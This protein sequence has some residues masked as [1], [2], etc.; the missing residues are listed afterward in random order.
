MTMFLSSLCNLKVAKKF[1]FLQIKRMQEM[2][3]KMQAQLQTTSPRAN[4]RVG[5]V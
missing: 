4:G 2:L 5:H 3:A 1:L